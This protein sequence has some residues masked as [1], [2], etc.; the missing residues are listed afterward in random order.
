[1]VKHDPFSPLLQ[2]QPQLVA[3]G[4]ERFNGA[5]LEMKYA[6]TSTVNFSIKGSFT[7][8]ITTASPDLPHEVSQP[9]TRLPS[10]NVSASL[11]GRPPATENGFTWGTGWMYLDGYVANY[12]DQRRDFLAYPG[13]GV[14][15]LSAGYLW[16]TKTRQIELDTGMRSALNRDLLA[17]NARVGAGREVVVS[18]RLTF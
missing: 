8:A 11:R 2:N 12:A 18:A 1:M 6:I 14:V 16:R 15:S 7:R 9:I 5:R 13:Y 4:E 3:D 10:Y 17:S